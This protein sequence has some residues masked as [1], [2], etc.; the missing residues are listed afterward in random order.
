MQKMRFKKIMPNHHNLLEQEIKS[1][2]ARRAI[3]EELEE[4]LRESMHLA[5]MYRSE[6]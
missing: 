3:L 1:L 2:E 5:R 4:A 6:E